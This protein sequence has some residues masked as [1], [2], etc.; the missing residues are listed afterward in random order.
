MISR[1]TS[2]T[3]F[4]DVTMKTIQE[5]KDSSSKRKYSLFPIHEKKQFPS[6]KKNINKRKKSYEKRFSANDLILRR[7]RKVK[8]ILSIITF[9]RVFTEDLGI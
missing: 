6:K 3:I 8:S 4:D 2:P 7:S 1:Y 5:R 9:I